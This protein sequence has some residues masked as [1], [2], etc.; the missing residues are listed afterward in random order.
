MSSLPVLNNNA[1]D[2]TRAT[3]AADLSR[4]LK[5]QVRFDAHHQLLY[6]TDASLYQVRPIGVVFPLSADD[7]S[8]TLNYCNANRISLLPRGGGTSLAGQCTNHAVVMD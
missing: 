6:S 8:A 2:T 7:V 3:I 1:A 5:G 4:L